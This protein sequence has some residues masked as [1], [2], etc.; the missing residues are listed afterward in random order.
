[1]ERQINNYRGKR[2]EMELSTGTRLMGTIHWI[3]DNGAVFGISDMADP[4]GA[5]VVA[6]RYVVRMKLV[7]AS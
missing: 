7:A 4:A 3:Q 1:M 2:V 6:T 5:D